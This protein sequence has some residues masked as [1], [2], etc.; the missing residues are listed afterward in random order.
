MKHLKLVLGLLLSISFFTA[1]TSS[2][3]KANEDG[4]G[5]FMVESKGAIVTKD[6]TYT[7][8]G[9]TM[10]GFVATPEGEGPFPGILVVHE[11]WGQTEYPRDRAKKLA[12]E[13]YVAMAVDM[14][15][16]G[17]T[18]S[19]PD[20]AKAFSKK[21][22]EDMDLAEESFRVALTTL[23]AQD[24]VDSTNIAA[25]GY[26][27]GGAVVLEMARRGVEMNMVASYHG[28][29]TPI[30]KNDVPNMKTR[31]LIFHG[32]DDSFVPKEAVATTR[33]KLKAAKVRYKF[34]S[35]KGAKHGFTNPEAT[36]NGEKFKI[37]LAYNERADSKSWDETMKAFQIVFK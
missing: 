28:D 5:Q 11:W 27:F 13:G 14:Y 2:E 37:P 24:K 8:G 15:G 23:K 9:K 16:D 29:L 36:A 12:M 33:Q 31:V 17:K 19:H 25:L 4:D 18:A 6:V 35:Y 20:D 26:C 10:K 34:I 3:E 22:M 7:S 21:V 1:C 32:A 30:V